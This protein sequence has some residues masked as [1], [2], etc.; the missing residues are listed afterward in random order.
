MVHQLASFSAIAGLVGPASK[1]G[2]FVAAEI[3]KMQLY[4]LTIR[5][6]LLF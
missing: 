6:L 2:R 5:L 3:D 1:T 4:S